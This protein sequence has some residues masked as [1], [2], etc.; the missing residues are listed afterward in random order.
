MVD[1]D[2]SKSTNEQRVEEPNFCFSGVIKSSKLIF[3]YLKWNIEPSYEGLVYGEP[4]AL[5]LNAEQ[6]MR[7]TNVHFCGIKSALKS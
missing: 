3:I 4:W 1:E 2:D 6:K 5:I 7:V